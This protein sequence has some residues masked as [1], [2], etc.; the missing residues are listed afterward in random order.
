MIFTATAG[1]VLGNARKV[2]GG[3]GKGA[4]V[5]GGWSPWCQGARDDY[6]G[7]GAPSALGVWETEGPFEELRGESRERTACA[8]SGLHQCP[9]RSSVP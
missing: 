7:M 8:C 4:G 1:N 3:G 2:V 6:L 9:S 5:E